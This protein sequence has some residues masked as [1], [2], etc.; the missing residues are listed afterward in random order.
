MFSQAFSYGG[1]GNESFPSLPKKKIGGNKSRY[2][3]TSVAVTRISL[4]QNQFV[5]EILIPWIRYRNFVTATVEKS[6]FKQL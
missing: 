1:N 3:H 6:E 4:P 5:T 2:H